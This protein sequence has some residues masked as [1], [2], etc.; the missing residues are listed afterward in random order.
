M[1]SDEDS[2]YFE[3]GSS[4]SWP[5]SESEDPSEEEVSSESEEASDRSGAED[6]R[7]ASSEQS[8]ASQSTSSLIT[9]QAETQQTQ[10]PSSSSILQSHKALRR[11][12]ELDSGWQQ[13]LS[14]S[15]C[16]SR[17][18]SRRPL[19]EDS[20]SFSGSGTTTPTRLQRR[21]SSWSIRP[22]SPRPCT[23]DQTS[24]KSS[25]SQCTTEQ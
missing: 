1:E 2:Y 8:I 15:G 23:T 5:G 16:F 19:D 10:V 6:S 7:S 20:E 9:P 12:K 3:E 24:P 18:I 11:T 21:Q 25:G 22:Q 4:G 14:E 17:A 13:G